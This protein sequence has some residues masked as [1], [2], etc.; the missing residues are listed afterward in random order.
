MANEALQC[1]HA[2]RLVVD[3]GWAAKSHSHDF[4]ELIVVLGGRLRVE[5]GRSE[6]VAGANDVLFYPVDVPHAERAEGRGRTDFVFLA[7]RGP[8]PDIVEYLTRDADGR[9]ACLARWLCEEQATSYEDRRR[10]MDAF[11]GAI[12]AE[13]AKL[14]RYRPIDPMERIR[15]HLRDH[16]PEAHCVDELA[17]MAGMSR[18]HFIRT[19]K[20]AT[21]RTPMEDLR[22]LRVEA[23]GD[24]LLTTDLPLKDVAEKVGFCDEYY[25]SRA[26]RKYRL[27]PPGRFRGKRW[28]GRAA[29][30]GR[31]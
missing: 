10:G 9:I 24:L 13:L 15:A 5:I 22:V 28:T 12:L 23:A 1:L 11:L 29:A 20:R 19:Y 16:L 21:G 6:V 27:V 17:A 18:H 31:R 26:F 3:P 7:V 4:V 8:A 14:V 25:F 2:G 30:A